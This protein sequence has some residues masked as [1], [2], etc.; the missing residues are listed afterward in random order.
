MGSITKV[1]RKFPGTFWTA[2]IMEL[3]E[4]LAW[5]GIFVPLALY[6]TGSTDTGA[7]GFTQAEKGTLLGTVVAVLYFLPVITGAIADKFGYKKVLIASFLIMATGYYLMGQVTTYGAVFCVFMWIALGA[8]LFKPVISATIG[9]TTDKDSS[10]IGFGIFY[11][12]VNIG[13]FLGPVIASN[14]RAISW[15][16][17]FTMSAVW[18]II[19]LLIIIFFYKEP[20][21]EKNTEPLGKS[22]VTIL[23][24]IWVSVSD[25]KL[26]VFLIIIIGFWTV[27]NQLFYTLPVFIEQWVDIKGLYDSIASFWQ[28]LAGAMDTQNNGSVAPEMLVNLG[29]FF[30]IL[31]QI[32]ISSLVMKMRPLRAMVAG[33]FVVTIGATM[34][35][36][37]R[38]GWFLI[39][40][41]FIF[42]VGEMSSSPKITEYMA[43]IA[44]KDKVA[45]YIG[46]SFLPLAGGH[47]F[48]GMISGGVYQRLS[49]KI[50]LLQQEMAT[51]GLSIPE[52]SDNFTQNDYVARATELMGMN[53]ATLIDYLWN[54]YNPSKIWI[55]MF[56]IGMVSVIALFLYDKLWLSKEP[57]LEN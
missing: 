19:N 38:N 27:Y 57:V 16:L 34:F 4:R 12:I 5:Y 51:R 52:I 10:S 11:M 7:L 35:F 28:G 56:G 54:T 46:C 14:L 47:F 53:E 20:A 50:Y 39:L 42:A 17:A 3:F 13:G 15:S 18:I 36:L 9:K 30:I 8:G 21:R 33:I 26:A 49:D 25:I 1:F 22:I 29:A 24:N 44:P 55:I 23:K 6:L 45:L 37:T 32:F 43:R 48:G 2:N 40:S 41:I 31:F